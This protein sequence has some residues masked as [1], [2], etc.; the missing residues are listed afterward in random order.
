MTERYANEQFYI[1][2]DTDK[3]LF[4]CADE[5]TLSVLSESLSGAVVT[6]LDVAFSEVIGPFTSHSGV[7]KSVALSGAKEIV[8]ENST[9]TPG[10]VID[11]AGVKTAVVDV[12]NDVVKL[13]GRLPAEVSP[14]VVLTTVGNTGVYRAPVLVETPG[15]YLFFVKHRQI[16]H[17][18]MSISIR[19]RNA[20]L[21]KDRFKA[22]V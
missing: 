16:G 19:D 12:D 11:I 1:K 9:I 5:F 20:L 8:V 17:L 14:G 15:E 18:A 21:G 10:D 7:V 6:D 4:D 22:F 13:R 2:V 3:D